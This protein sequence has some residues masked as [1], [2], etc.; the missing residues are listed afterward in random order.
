VKEHPHLYWS[1]V[2]G[3]VFAA[4]AVIVDRVTGLPLLL[5]YLAAANAGTYLLYR[6]DKASAREGE[7]GRIPNRVLALLAMFGGALGAILGMYVML[8][9]RQTHKTSD[10]YRA[11]RLVV[12]L[13]L[14]GHLALVYCLLLDPAGR[15]R[16]WWQDLIEQ[17]AAGLWG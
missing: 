11:L 14:F 15:C 5:V 3:V 17:L 13:S 12:W 1:V 8:L 16:A 7:A 6:L 9:P 10:K 4:L 2:A